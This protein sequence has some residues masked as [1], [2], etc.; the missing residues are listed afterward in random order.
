MALEHLRLEDMS[1][2]EVLLVMLDVAD[3]E[4]YVDPTDIAEHL[5]VRGDNPRR[6][7]SARMAWLKRFGA[8]EKEFETDEHGNVMRRRNNEP[9]TTQRYRLTPIGQDIANGTLRATQEKSLEGFH[10]GQIVMLTQ[11]LSQRASGSGTT[12][13]NLVR[14]EWQYRTMFARRNGRR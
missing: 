8:V 14:R 4:G 5:G 12:V 3:D 11:W 9:R 1:D 2:R 13:S 7:V 6:V 10:D